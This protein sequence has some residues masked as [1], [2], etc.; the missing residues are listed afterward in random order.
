MNFLGKT[1]FG[2][3]TF[4]WNQMPVSA[5]LILPVAFPSQVTAPEYEPLNQDPASQLTIIQTFYRDLLRNLSAN[6]D[7]A[8]DDILQY[9]SSQKDSKLT[10]QMTLE[11]F[12]PC[13]S[14]GLLKKWFCGSLNPRHK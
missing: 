14:T 4:K 12:A 11:S 8:V 7:P 9:N 5:I 2:D 10:F 1:T 13:I 3:D 6:W